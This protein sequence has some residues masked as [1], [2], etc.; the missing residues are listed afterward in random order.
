MDE[1]SYNMANAL[2]KRGRVTGFVNTEKNKW[3]QNKTSS[4]CKPRGLGRSQT[5]WPFHPEILGFRTV[6]K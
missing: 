4:V 6:R 2:I 5:N 1:S 3:G